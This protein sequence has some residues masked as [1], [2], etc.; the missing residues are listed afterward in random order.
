MKINEFLNHYT[1][2]LNEKGFESASLDVEVLFCKVT[3]FSRVDLI[4]KSY[5]EVSKKDE[6]S[7]KKLFERRLEHEPIAYIL[8]KKSFCGFDFK[9]N[10]N[11]LIPRPLT[12]EIVNCVVDDVQGNKFKM[13][14]DI[15]IIDIG[16]GSGC[17]IISIVKNILNSC[18]NS[19]FHF[20]ASDISKKALKVAK[21]NAKYFCV[22]ENINFLKGNLKFP[23]YGRFDYIIANLPYVNQESID[24]SKDEQ[25]DLKFEPKLALFHKD[26]GFFLIRKLLKKITKK[27]LLKDDGY[28]FLE[29]EK[30]QSERI[31]YEFDWYFKV[32]EAFDGRIV[33]LSKN[34][35]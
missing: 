18:M 6:R 17:I 23:K 29:V 28:I 16:T 27:N 8:G 14:S 21:N 2:I 30:G 25:K 9:I 10:K 1:A 5:D 32:E 34:V 35:D 4:A 22:N 13:R 20:F 3:G 33:R 19:R 31:R 15:N 11:V 7:F 12:E 26:N 24:Y